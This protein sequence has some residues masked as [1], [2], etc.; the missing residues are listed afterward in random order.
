M[1]DVDH[2][3]LINDTRG[4]LIGDALLREAVSQEER[5]ETT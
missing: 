3:K 2:F 1:L 4:H 5:A